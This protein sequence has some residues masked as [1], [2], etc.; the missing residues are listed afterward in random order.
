LTHSQ[1]VQPVDTARRLGAVVLNYRTAADT[2]LAVRS[3]Q[4]SD[5]PIAP[6][7]V[8]DN[9]SADD[10]LDCFRRH[11]AQ[12]EVIALDRNAGFSGGCNAG[13]RRALTAGVDDI[14]LA[15]SDAVVPPDAPGVLR[16]ILDGNPRVGIVSAIVRRR[17]NPDIVESIGMSYDTTSGRM[18]LLDHGRRIEQVAPFDSRVVDAVS[19]CAMLVRREVFAAIGLLRDEY[20]FGFEDLDYCCRARIAGWLCAC[21]GSTFVLHEGNR[22][23]GRHSA[24]RAY[25][26]TRNHLLVASRF[27]PAGSRVSR[28]L[29]LA[30]VLALNAAHAAASREIP[31]GSGL[32]ATMRGARDF[33]RGRLGDGRYRIEDR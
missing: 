17:S 22:S 12:V 13:I 29:R 10:S 6:V 9:G 3:L 15:N 4:A 5:T 8:V 14:L 19:G 1:R 16:R 7:V 18:R 25:F 23:I 28:S 26:A 30:A 31:I 27:P 2:I 20:F 33:A 24:T 32:M 21:A 11:L